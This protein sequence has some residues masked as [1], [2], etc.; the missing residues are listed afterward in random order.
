MKRRSFLKGGIALGILPLVPVLPNGLPTPP[1]ALPILLPTVP[2]SGSSL[3]SGTTPT[4]ILGVV[5]PQSGIG[6]E[7]QRQ[8]VDGVRAAL[9][10]A[11]TVRGALDPLLDCH[12]F[13]DGGDP[14]QA[15]AAAQSCV[16][17]ASVIGTIGHL[18]GTTTL[19]ARQTYVRAGMPLLIPIATLDRLTTQGYTNL[20]RLATRDTLEGDLFASD[21]IKRNLLERVAVIRTTES[22]GTEVGAAFAARCRHERI[23]V[24][25][26]LM[27]TDAQK[28]ADMVTALLATS[29]EHCYLAGTPEHLGDIA[30][31]LRS[32]GYRG[33]FLAPQSFFEG[34]TISQYGTALADMLISSSI[35]PFQRAPIN[36]IPLAD[37][38]SSYGTM[39][40]IAAFGYAAAQIA[41]AAIRR[42]AAVDRPSL[43]RALRDGSSTSTIVGDFAF[44]PFGD[45][46]DPNLFLYRIVGQEWR[47]ERSLHPTSFSITA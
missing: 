6:T 1:P 2:P 22:Y 27:P 13:D 38:A 8:L 26:W 4:R 45:P 35:P 36:A 43:L 7:Q 29:P 24:T 3:T 28:R 46:T 39:T 41:V 10:E 11:N 23:T 20:I 18:S 17:D 12:L 19:A 34:G 32:G 42:G 33:A 21:L 47:Y 31:L 30:T 9:A 40:P 37:F 16:D 44:T 15:E 5:G 25:E 14:L